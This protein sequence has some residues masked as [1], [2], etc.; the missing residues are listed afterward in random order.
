[1]K[2]LVLKSLIML[3]MTTAVFAQNS[4]N[5]GWFLGGLMFCRYKMTFQIH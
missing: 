1:M 3:L 5:H 4:D 2:K